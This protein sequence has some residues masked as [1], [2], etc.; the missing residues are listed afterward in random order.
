MSPRDIRWEIVSQR[1]DVKSASFQIFSCTDPNPTSPLG[2]RLPHAKPWEWEAQAII[3]QSSRNLRPGN[4]LVVGWSVADE[5]I[6]AVAHLIPETIDGKYSVHVA[7]IGVST[8]VRGQ[9]GEVADRTLE[10]VHNV[11]LKDP[12]ASAARASFATAKIHTRN[13]ASQ[14]LFERAGYEP[15]GIPSGDYQLWI[16]RLDA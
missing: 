10:E 13:L 4:L 7:A 3:R 11:S 1:R 6:V 8:G 2:R 15:Q 14:R 16:C 5:N 9:G 12:R